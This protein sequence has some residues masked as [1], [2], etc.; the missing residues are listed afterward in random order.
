MSDLLDEGELRES[1]ARVLF[2]AAI[3]QERC[4]EVAQALWSHAALRLGFDGRIEIEHA[5]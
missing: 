5:T 4:A 2:V 1:A 3:E